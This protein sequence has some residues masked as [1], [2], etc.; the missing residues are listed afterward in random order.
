MTILTAGPSSPRPHERAPR[1]RIA[2][3]GGG[4]A[5]LVCADRLRDRHDVTLFEANDYIGGHTNTVDVTLGGERHAIDTG[6]I[7]YN[8]SNYPNF[9]RLLDRLD[10]ATQPTTMSFSVRCDRT[11]LEYNGTSINR[12]FAQRRNLF[13]PRFHRMIRDILRFGREATEV[14]DDDGERLTVGDYVSE[15]GYGAEFVEH[16]LVPM[17]ASIWSCP[18]STFRA[19]P[20]RFVVEFLRNH[21]M[22]DVSGRPQWRVV[23][24]G[25][26]CY[27]DALTR[28]FTDRI[29]LKTPVRRVRR[30]ADRVEITA[31]RDGV[32][33]FDHVIFACHSD[34]ALRV[35]EDPSPTERELLA[36]FPYQRNE[37][38]LHT[39]RS[40]LP[41]RRLAWAAWNYHLRRDDPSAVAV[42]YNMNILQRLASRHTF[43]VTL[44]DDAGIAPERVIQRFDYDHPV[45]TTGRAAAQRRHHEVID[46]SRTSFCGAYWGYGFHEDGVKSALRV[47]NAFGRRLA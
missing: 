17:G 9:T 40:V 6:F 28:P 42:T 45:Y 27:V 18:P 10:V 39:D 41:R 19:F 11:G 1:E 2:I 32:E 44:N 5:G 20:I 16:Y 37:A 25:S 14:L 13:R 35:L 24:G 7:V 26:R 8:E 12:L 23:R 21:A 36:A 38:V 4:I 31:G 43:C 47:A 29:R 30:H 22:L 15:R 3:V 33:V 34:Q 46:A